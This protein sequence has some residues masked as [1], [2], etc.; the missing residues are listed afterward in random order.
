MKQ[1]WTLTGNT[2]GMAVVN[3][4][5][6]IVRNVSLYRCANNADAWF[7]QVKAELKGSKGER[8]EGTCVHRSMLESN[9]TKEAAANFASKVL[10]S[11]E[12]NL[13]HWNVER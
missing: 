2:L 8:L 4:G 5:T 9:W 10:M 1:L 12:I 6:A 7:I 13:K 3:N 11:G